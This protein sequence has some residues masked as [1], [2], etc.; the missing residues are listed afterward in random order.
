MAHPGAR[1]F[2]RVEGLPPAVRGIAPFTPLYWGTQGYRALLEKGAGVS[3]IA[4]HTAVLSTMGIVLL[5]IGMLA[6]RR[7]ARQGVGA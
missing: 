3:G 1:G 6:L 7:S 5:A 4:T 2:I